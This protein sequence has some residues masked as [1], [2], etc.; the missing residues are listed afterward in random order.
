MP[1]ANPE[2]ALGTL[3]AP[4]RLVDF[5]NYRL[6]HL[7]RVAMSASG[8][9]LRAAAGVSRRE[10]RMLAFLGEQPGTRLTELA[11]SA[12]LDKVLASRAV[13]ALMERGLVRK[14]AQ[15][16]D[17]RAA[18][19]TLT[20]AGES[21]YAAAFA[22]A[23]DFNRELAGCL[24]AAEAEVFSRCLDKLHARAVAMRMAAEPLAD[25][26]DDAATPA[27]DD[28]LSVWHRR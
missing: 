1:Q 12:G 26:G 17:R 2:G 20:E 5:V 13:H 8:L 23:R 16:A 10:W 27:F 7:S 28:P 22:R 24:D 15:A 6:Y 14:T 11:A 21:V 25:K 9:H 4:A 3:Q 19:F 18:A